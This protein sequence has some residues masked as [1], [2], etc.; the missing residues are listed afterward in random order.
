MTLIKVESI[1]SFQKSYFE[2]PKNNKIVLEYFIA[3]IPIQDIQEKLLAIPRC[4][5]SV[6]L[7]MIYKLGVFLYKSCLASH[8]P[9][10]CEETEPLT[11]HV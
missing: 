6:S 8:S 3:K 1:F 4:G 11:G 2:Y 10:V 9:G 7:T 5:V